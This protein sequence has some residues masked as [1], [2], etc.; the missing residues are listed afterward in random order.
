MNSIQKILTTIL[1]AV[2]TG[3]VFYHIFIPFIKGLDDA[4]FN[5]VMEVIKNLIWPI[6]IIVFFVFFKKV[7]TYLFLSLDSFNFFGIKGNLKD[8][9]ELII[10]KAEELVE[11]EKRGTIN[12]KELEKIKLSKED[13]KHKLDEAI[14]LLERKNEEY[15][16]LLRRFN[17]Y[18]NHLVHR[19]FSVVNNH[20]RNYREFLKNQR[21]YLARMARKNIN[22]QDNN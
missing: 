7:F 19:N 20:D 21:D 18:R 2:L 12:K 5:R 9:Q 14:E 10:E 6:I 4:T 11:K 22:H 8:P 16:S 17:N 13:T 15:E 3:V 1:L